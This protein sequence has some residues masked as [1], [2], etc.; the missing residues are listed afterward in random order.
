MAL[1]R[2]SV[3]E[4]TYGT[5]ATEETQTA[6]DESVTEQRSGLV[7]ATSHREPETSS[8]SQGP[9]GGPSPAEQIVASS[10][11]AK[12]EPSDQ[13]ERAEKVTEREAPAERPIPLRTVAKNRR[14]QT[15]DDELARAAVEESFRS[16]KRRPREWGSAPIRIATTVK[17]RLAA[18]RA[19]DEETFGVKF[20]ETHYLDAALARVPEDPAIAIEWAERY[21]DSFPL[22]APTTVGTTGR[23]RTSTIEHLERVTRAV[24]MKAGY[25]FIGHLQTA[26]LERLL[27]SL[28][29]W[30]AENQSRVV[31]LD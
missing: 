12:R 24:R 30:D 23:V 16:A 27:D 20:A 22:K 11:A 4:G 14:A 13:T 29:R 7:D 8:A 15:R 25:G 18:R 26:A 2:Q 5:R 19:L 6:K 3:L 31:D 9:L 28:D 1:K 17:D 21:L 10:G